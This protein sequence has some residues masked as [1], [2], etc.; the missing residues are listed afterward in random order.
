MAFL[1]IAFE[2]WRPTV[3]QLRGR[4]LAHRRDSLGSRLLRH[5]IF[6]VALREFVLHR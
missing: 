3:T 5:G 6:I 2:E 1:Q 4:I